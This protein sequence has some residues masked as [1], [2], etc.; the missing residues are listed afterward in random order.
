MAGLEKGRPGLVLQFQQSLYAR[1]PDCH[2]HGEVEE[3]RVTVPH[4]AATQDL[5]NYF[6]SGCLPLD[7]ECLVFDI[8]AE[9]GG[10]YFYR[11]L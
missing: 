3:P 7:T 1:L 9:A 4:L 8:H 11:G 5:P 2:L 6:G 10:V